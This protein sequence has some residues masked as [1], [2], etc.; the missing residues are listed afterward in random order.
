MMLYV[1]LLMLD[2]LAVASAFQLGV[3]ARYGTVGWFAPMDI[4]V[5]TLPLYII[6]AFNNGAYSIDALRRTSFSIVR[7]SAALMLAFASFLFISYYF[8]ILQV[9]SRL[10]IS[11]GMI[12]SIILVITIRVIF[13][14][15]VK[16]LI[17]YRLTSDMV[18]L[19]D[20]KIAIPD[21]YHSVDAHTA[22]LRPN[23]RDPMMLD[24][25][26]RHLRHVD[27]VIIACKPEKERAWAMLLKGAGIDGEIISSEFDQVGAIGINSFEGRSTMVVAAGP[28]STRNR[29]IKRVFDLAFA[30][31]A[32]IGLL[33]LLVITALAIKLDSPGPVFFRQQRVGRGNALFEVFKF[34]SMRVEAS[35]ASGAV[36]ASR[37]DDRVTRVGKIIRA[38]SMD[39]LPQLLN[40]LFGSMSIVGPRPHA[41]GSLAGQQLFWDVD[42]RYWHRHALKPGITGLAQVRGF[43]GATHER[44]D[45]VKRLQADL[46]YILGWSVVRDFR[47]VVSTIGVV[48][49][50]NAF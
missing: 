35:D 29:I 10:V 32:L 30:I 31:P 49:H 17:G 46:E 12:G 16:L 38:T 22:D 44:D 6:S 23:A 9:E 15:V 14:K 19:D 47:I 50:R 26:A 5:V 33:P 3:L 8:R 13:D 43:R 20:V 7:S 11:T 40:V 1:T 21:Y 4:V 36:S 39:E 2:I 34:R 18:I 45:L 37:T 42:E 48:V 25:L 28:L 24:R 41:L 27:R